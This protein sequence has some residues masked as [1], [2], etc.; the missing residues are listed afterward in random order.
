MNGAGKFMNAFP[1]IPDPPV[2]GQEYLYQ[3]DWIIV[4]PSSYKFK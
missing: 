3:N 4:S 1:T 2:E